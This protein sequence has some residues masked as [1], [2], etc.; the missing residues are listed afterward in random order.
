MILR[1]GFILNPFAGIGG[2]LGQKGSDLVELQR[3]AAKGE[4]PLCSPLR[5]Q[6]FWHLLHAF[7][8]QLNILSAPHIMGSQ[9]LSAWN[10]PHRILPYNLTSQSTSQ[11]T[12]AIVAAMMAEG[13]DIIVFVGGDGTARDIYAAVGKHAL[14]LGIPSGVKMHSGVYAINPQAAAEV[15][16]QLLRGD[17]MAETLQEVRDI[18]EEAFR[19]N[20]V[21]S[22]YF[23]Q[24][25][26][27]SSAEFIQAVKQGGEESDELAVLE[28]ADY[29]RS[30]L[31]PE[32]LMIFAPG[33]TTHQILAEWGYGGTLLGVDILHPQLGLITDVN[34]EKL[35]HYCV[36]FKNN[37]ALVLTAIGGQ[38]HIIGRGNQQLTPELLRGIGREHLHVVA[39][40]RKLRTLDKRPLLMDSG[41]PKLD[42]QWQGLI[43]VITGYNET[44]L[45]PVGFFKD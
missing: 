37:V 26:T 44:L 31:S 2:P 35:S 11:D 27:P 22:Q 14:V 18:D 30:Q 28:I 23:G 38:G 12:Q 34:A 20:I 29:L 21:K 6:T 17:L 9:W 5:A 1:I 36:A 33:S 25:R 7:Y 3:A 32:A 19:N 4:I 15:I 13:I 42:L 24:M 41:D 8:D 45:Y 40:K 39:T 43:P 10:I 16:Q